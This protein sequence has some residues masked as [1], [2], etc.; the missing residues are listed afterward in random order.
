MDKDGDEEQAVEVR[1][2]RRCAD[3]GSPEETHG[4]IGDIVLESG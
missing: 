3:D 1:D 2:E 4:P